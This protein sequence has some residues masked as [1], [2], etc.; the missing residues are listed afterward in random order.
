LKGGSDEETSAKKV[1]TLQ[2]AM[3]KEGRQ[4]FKGKKQVTASV[5]APGDTSLSDAT[6]YN[7]VADTDSTH[8]KK[9]C[10]RLS[11]SEA[12]FLMET[13]IFVCFWA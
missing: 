2:R 7:F 11:S 4:F 1:I 13:S 6:G 9:L 3:T 8:T 5:T 10:S 12:H